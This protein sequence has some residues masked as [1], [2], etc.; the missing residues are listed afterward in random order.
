M[1]TGHKKLHGSN[2]TIQHNAKNKQ[3]KGNAKRNHDI[4]ERK[5]AIER[6]NQT[7]CRLNVNYCTPIKRCNQRKWKIEE[8]KFS[9][10]NLYSSKSI[11]WIMKKEKKQL[12]KHPNDAVN[13]A[14]DV[15]SSSLKL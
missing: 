2:E 5:P 15:W 4:E 8:R 1:T 14:V 3:G 7:I 9:E 10:K 11:K 12:M 6:W 13:D